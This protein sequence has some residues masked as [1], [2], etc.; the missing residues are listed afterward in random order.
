MASTEAITTAG[1]ILKARWVMG[2]AV[3]GVSWIG[4]GDGTWSDKSN[5]PPVSIAATALTHEIARKHV[6]RTAWLELD[7][8]NGTV[9]WAGNRYREVVG[10]TPIAA[11]FAD[12]TPDECSGVQ[13]CE[14]GVFAGE[15]VTSAAPF[16]LAAEVTQS[17]TLYWVR[18]REIQT[19]GPGDTFTAVAVYE[20]K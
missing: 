7:N 10:P 17:G 4:I 18:N 5:P 2:E 20:E 13:V 11:L 19:K 3:K 6:Q 12:F 9:Y 14:E 8:I 16:A 15:V 1:R